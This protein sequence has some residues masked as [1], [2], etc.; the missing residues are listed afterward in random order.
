MVGRAH[1]SEPPEE[2]GQDEVDEFV[3]VAPPMIPEGAEVGAAGGGLARGIVGQQTA[4]AQESGLETQGGVGGNLRGMA[5]VREVF[6]EAAHGPDVVAVAEGGAQSFPEGLFP[7]GLAGAGGEFAT[8]SLE[9]DAGGLFEEFAKERIGQVSE[10]AVT[11]AEGEGW[12][13][14]VEVHPGEQFFEGG[15]E[16]FPEGEGGESAGGGVGLPDG[17]EDD[18]AVGGVDVV[19]M[20]SPIWGADVDFDVAVLGRGAVELDHR[21]LEIGASP[22]IPEAR[23]KDPQRF[24]V[25]GLEAVGAESLVQPDELEQAF[26]GNAFAGFPEGGGGQGRGAP[27]RV[28]LRGYQHHPC[29]LLFGQGSRKVKSAASRPWWWERQRKMPEGKP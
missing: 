15:I 14:E 5:E 17:M 28:E 9:A 18:A 12:G 3:A 10:G 27:L 6:R 13:F 22:M 20:G 21:P 8:F 16:A 7:A 4:Q 29:P 24:A 11:E 1:S 19:M 26:A 2:L 23:M 25:Q